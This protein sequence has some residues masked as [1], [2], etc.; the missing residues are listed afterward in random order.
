MWQ[1]LT[2]AQLFA[3]IGQA[4][5]SGAQQVQVH[6]DP[7]GLYPERVLVNPFMLMADDDSEF[8]ISDFVV[9]QP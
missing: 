4:F 9:L 6:Y 1:F 2:I 5:E 3:E 7:S 8:E